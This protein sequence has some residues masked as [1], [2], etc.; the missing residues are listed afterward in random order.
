MSPVSGSAG[1]LTCKF[2]GGALPPV[3]GNT[4]GNEA[5]QAKVKSMLTQTT[6]YFERVTSGTK[7]W[8]ERNE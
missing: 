8:S 4:S 6:K 7:V 1:V 5:N 3:P 2:R